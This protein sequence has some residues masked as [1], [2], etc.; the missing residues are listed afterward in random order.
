[1]HSHS[2]D[3]ALPQPRQ[4]HFTVFVV[5]VGFLWI[6]GLIYG[7]TLLLLH[8]FDAQQSSSLLPADLSQIPIVSRNE[9]TIRILIAVH[10]QC[11][12]TQNTLGELKSILS[13]A[14]EAYQ[15][16]ALAFTPEENISPELQQQWLATSNIDFFRNLPQSNIVVDA[17]GEFARQLDLPT[18]GTI[19][20]IDVDGKTIFRGGI[21]GSR[22][23]V[24]DNPGSIAV[25]NILSGKIVSPTTTPIF[26]CSIG[27][28]E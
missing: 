26:G 25:R 2:S 18:S 7:F 12:C 14:T 19:T 8:D 10:P 27:G 28:K 17:N 16:T 23:C 21:T 3:T 6:A 5:I 1:M 20:V 4:N 13:H 9:D 22:S 11:P 24:I 15:L